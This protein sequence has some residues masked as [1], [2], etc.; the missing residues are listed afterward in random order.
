MP[1]TH[2]AATPNRLCTATSPYLRQ[3]ADNPVDWYPWGEEALRRAR[4]ADKPI[5]LS[6][7]YAACHWCHVMAHESFENAEIARLLNAYF[8][9]IKVDREERP[10]LDELYMSATVLYT[11]G[12]GGWPMSVF[13]TPQLEPFFAGTYFP[14]ESRRGLPGFKEILSSIASLWRDDRRRVLDSADMLTRVVRDV[15]EPRRSAGAEGELSIASAVDQL[16]AAMDRT[17]GGFVSGATNKFPPSAALT[18][19]LWEDYRSRQD[20]RPRDELRALVALTLDHMARGG[21]TDHLAGGIARYS[22][23][24]AWLVPHFEKML[25]DQAQVASVSIEA[26]RAIGDTQSAEMARE[27]LTYV[28]DDLRAPEGGFYCSRDADSE[29]GEGR[30]YVWSRD[31][32]IET[33]GQELGELICHYYNVTAQGQ[34]EGHNILHVPV[35]FERFA[36]EHG[37]G[38][39]DLRAK[40]AEARRRLLERRS[41]RTPPA[42][43]D[44]IV[45]EWNGL[46]VGALARGGR[47]LRET[48]FTDAARQA[49]EFLLNNMC[50]ENRLYRTWS[51]GQFH[52][53]G[54]LR[55]YACLVEGLLELYGASW[56]PRW[57]TEAVRWAERMI[58]HFQDS[59]SGAFFLTA[60]DA[61][62]V[63]VRL[64]DTQD[65]AVPSGSSVAIMNLLRL[66]WML[67]REDFH[68]SAQR[69]IRAI[70][71]RA[72]RSPF[73]AERFLTAVAFAQAE[74]GQVVVAG[75]RDDPRTR[76]LLET[77]ERI[78]DPFR[79]ELL[80]ESGD[81]DELDGLAAW[82]TDKVPLDGQPTGYV[83]RGRTC[84]RPVTD[85]DAL[86]GQLTARSGNISP[87]A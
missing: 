36:K 20:G 46:M 15:T 63:L 76:Q 8:I 77:M 9:P 13:L 78:Y 61:E 18:L 37:I 45:T 79:V 28:L 25:Y 64:P 30:Y 53:F 38:L 21:I 26:Y 47:Y 33:L 57:L 65:G 22:T 85:P 60:D 6:I 50:K 10:D 2:E 54:F 40:L 87:S 55:D 23:D 68:A 74:P 81:S 62:T 67:E 1:K 86:S 80:R 5:F 51:H 42:L 34:W 58:A 19:M 17:R 83:C 31:E 84:Q 11:R 32:I 71:G 29:Q 4:D 39:D 75:P 12:H 24:T 69:A 70:S 48:R 43:D 14:P 73:G 27:I 16:V 35:P 3:H 52:T 41:Q 59:A 72:A 66:G 82:L 49:A 44:K 56:E 7:G